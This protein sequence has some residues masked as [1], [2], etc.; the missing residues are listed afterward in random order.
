MSIMLLI[1]LAS[2]LIVVFYISAKHKLIVR[3]INEFS[4]KN[5]KRAMTRKEKYT[6]IC[7][8]ALLPLVNTYFALIII[9]E[10]II[11]IL[12]KRKFKT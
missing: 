8:L 3:L 4:I 12:I 10:I 6:V 2:V 1:Y 9:G 11:K 7:T 5:S